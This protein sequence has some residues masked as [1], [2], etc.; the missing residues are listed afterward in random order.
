MSAAEDVVAHRE[1]LAGHQRESPRRRTDRTHPQ[2][3]DGGGAVADRRG[4][5]EEAEAGRAV[6]EQDEAVRESTA[7]YDKWS[8]TFLAT[9]KLMLKIIKV[10]SFV[11]QARSQG[12]L[13]IARTLMK[14]NAKWL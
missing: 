14:D 9:A 7:Q 10:R 6:G 12:L 4:R 8:D 11:K 2:Q 13:T 1:C 3:G 5:I